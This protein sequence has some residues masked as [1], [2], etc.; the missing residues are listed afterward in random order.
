[1]KKIILSLITAMVFASAYPQSVLKNDLQELHLKGKVKSMHESFYD[2]VDKSGEIVKGKKTAKDDDVETR[3]TFNDKGYKTEDARFDHHGIPAMV[4]TYAYDDKS[5]RIEE[6]RYN[7]VGTLVHK[8]K[9]AYKYNDSGK[10]IEKDEVSDTSRL[11]KQSETYV[12]DAKGN[13]VEENWYIT[14]GIVISKTTSK[15]DDKGN[16][17]ET[18]HYND[19]TPEMRVTYKMG[20]DGKLAE[21]TWYNKGTKFNIMYTYKYDD[22]G[23]KSEM[24]WCKENGKSFKKWTFKYVYDNNNNWTQEIQF[25]ND[26]PYKIT[27][28]TLEYF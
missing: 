3:V 8:A 11:S 19:R 28:R 22:K 14:V 2:A 9:F 13:L 27:E 12:Y 18:A 21:E 20:N 17:I 1:M 10:V 7:T 24:N 15:F 25:K 26:K 16:I 5:N 23:N 4:L 6:A